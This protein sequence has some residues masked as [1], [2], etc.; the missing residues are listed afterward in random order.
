V[1]LSVT[2]AWAHPNVI[3]DGP[4]VV[5][6]PL[7][8]T[9]IV[10]GDES[11]FTGV[12]IT[13]PVWVTVD[14]ASAHGFTTTTTSH[15]VK[16]TDGDV[17]LGG[18][19]LVLIDVTPRKAQT[20]DVDIVSQF[21]SGTSYRYPVIGVGVDGNAVGQSAGTGT[22]RSRIYLEVGA[23]LVITTTVGILWRRRYSRA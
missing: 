2:P 8:L 13:L 20:L 1:L 12:D 6:H 7:R 5:G 18:T 9:V 10:L 19:Q 21:K 11:E 17:N 16:L 14:D 22:P 15:T 3:A 23:F 4:I